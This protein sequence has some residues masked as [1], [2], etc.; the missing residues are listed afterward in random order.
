MYAYELSKDL[1]LPIA[2]VMETFHRLESAGCVRQVDEPV[3]AP[4]QSGGWRPRVWFELTPEGKDFAA[5]TVSE[6]HSMA[7]V[8]ARSIGLNLGG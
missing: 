8:Q 4:P 2:A 6:T 3:D 5:A 7:R 1:Y